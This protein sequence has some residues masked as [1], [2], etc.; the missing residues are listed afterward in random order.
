MLESTYA[1]APTLPPRVDDPPT[2]PAP[3]A[4]AHLSADDLASAV[5]AAYAPSTPASA[6]TLSTKRYLHYERRSLWGQAGYNIGYSYVAGIAL[7]GTVGGLLGLR[8]SPNS[9]PRVLLNSL[10]NGAGKFGAKAGNVAGVA[11]LVYTVVERRMESVEVDKLP[12][13][14]NAVAGRALFDD[15]SASADKLIPLSSAFLTGVLFTLPRAVT[16]RGVDK[17]RVTFAKRAGVVLLGGGLGVIA[18]A[19]A[20]V[21]GA[22]VWGERN[23]F[24]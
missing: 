16:M 3:H 14:V 17:A 9:S 12:G 4:H 22:A 24:R 21:V 2:P 23:P 15:R 13:L 6:A 8:R 11:A 7:G 10:L 20:A 18:A 19:G 5:G 1:Q